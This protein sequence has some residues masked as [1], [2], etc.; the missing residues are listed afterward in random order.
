VRGL[1]IRLGLRGSKV[2]EG[3]TELPNIRL[4][5]VRDSHRYL[6][7]NFRFMSTLLSGF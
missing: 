1:G 7:L 6:F 5:P 2:N 4:R 3:P